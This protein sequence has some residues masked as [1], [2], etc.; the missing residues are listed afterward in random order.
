[1]PQ[2]T[3]LLCAPGKKNY[4]LTNEKGGYDEV[5]R[6]VYKILM[7]NILEKPTWRTEKEMGNAI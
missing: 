3:T 2:P 1:V 5:T 7:G 6:N 4:S